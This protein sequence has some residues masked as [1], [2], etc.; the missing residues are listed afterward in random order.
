MH[1]FLLC[2]ILGSIL[3]QG[4]YFPTV[5]LIVT[6]LLS[7]VAIVIKKRAVGSCEIIAFV[8]ALFYYVSSLANGY[9]SASLAQASLL[10][11][12][13]MFLYL[14]NCLPEQEKSQLIDKLIIGSGVF[15]GL[16]ILAFCDVIDITGAV[17]SQRLQFTFQYANAA[18]SWFA[19]IALLSQGRESP[20]VKSFLIPSLVALFL[21]RSVGALGMYV[22]VQLGR[23]W[24]YRN[25]RHLW[26][27]V[28]I[29]HILSAIFAIAFFFLRSWLTLPVVALLYLVGFYLQQI[30]SVAYR[31]YL[32]WVCLGCSVLGVV[33]ILLSRRM[34]SALFTFAERIS[35]IVDGSRLI[36]SH[37]L[38][39]VGAGNWTHLYPYYQSAQYTSTVVHSSIIQ[40]GVDA[41]L[42][43]II[44]AVLFV[45]LALRQKGRPIAST[46]AAALLLVHSLM[47][48]TLQFFPICALLIALLFDVPSPI[49]TQKKGLTGPIVTTLALCFC[50]FT[51]GLLYTE[52]QSKQLVRDAQRGLWNTILEE[53][54]RQKAM[55]GKNQAAESYYIYALYYTGDF[56]GVIEATQSLQMSDTAE[57]LLCAQS[58][59][60]LGDQDA[61]CELL[62]SELERQ[63]YRVVLYEQISQCLLDWNV[64]IHYLEEYNRIVDLANASQTIL[65]Q[66][67]GDQVHINHIK[68]GTP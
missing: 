49:P 64:D 4:G 37:P 38:F 24:V 25:D 52:L 46:L 67:Q 48:F 8:A 29:T 51:T 68:G 26:R 32:H 61:A 31:I 55:Y 17:T 1:I 5:I 36:V 7:G 56:E 53:Y 22:V 34:A 60:Q 2:V 50:I 58:L 33:G 63:M 59:R 3:I 10:G 65:G 43:A 57:L 15:A 30:L 16:A 42:P 41:G 47:D 13:A 6:I 44:L 21:T 18:G 9:N 19:T 28:L 35:Q 62:L 45:I 14:Y 12:C 20:K 66:L 54:E 39:G 23:L 11:G 40:I 27:E